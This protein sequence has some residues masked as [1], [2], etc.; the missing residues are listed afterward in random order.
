MTSWTDKS[1]AVSTFVNKAIR[2]KWRWTDPNA[3]WSDPRFTWS[4][5]GTVNWT[6]LGRVLLAYLRCEDDTYLLLEDGGRIVIA[7]TDWQNRP[8][9]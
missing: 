6:D 1:K 5:V 8:K 4:G 7:G 2:G 3:L 9:H